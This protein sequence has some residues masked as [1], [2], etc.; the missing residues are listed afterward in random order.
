[1]AS[2]SRAAPGYINGQKI[3]EISSSTEDRTINA[4]NLYGIDGVLGQSI[5]A[6]E[7]K[8]D[9]DTVVL[10]QGMQIQMDDI[11]GVPITV[12]S[13]RNGRMI[14]CDGLISTSNY[15]SDSK[16]GEVKG[17]FGFMG[18]APRFA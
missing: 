14:L 2:I 5:G 1:M 17:K 10:I 13:I 3:A 9:F 16:S 18:G 11:I 12:S 6:D 15:A 8:F 4:A 7:V